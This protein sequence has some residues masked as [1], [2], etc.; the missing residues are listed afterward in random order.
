LDWLRFLTF[1]E[2]K[3]RKSRVNL[4]GKTELNMTKPGGQEK[5]ART[6]NYAEINQPSNSFSGRVPVR[7]IYLLQPKSLNLTWHVVAFR[8]LS[9]HS[10]FFR[11]KLIQEFNIIEVLILYSFRSRSH[12]ENLYLS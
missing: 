8:D 2:K 3:V 4:I 11:E 6:N 10:S 12:L 5:S 1:L 9:T 7:K